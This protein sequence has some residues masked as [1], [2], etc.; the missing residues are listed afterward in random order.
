MSFLPDELIFHGPFDDVETLP[1]RIEVISGGAVKEEHGVEDGDQRVQG[2][3][4][5]GHQL[6][7]GVL[8]GERG[9]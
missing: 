7:D 3:R 2:L 1:A 5:V 6:Q 4:V 8:I 9:K